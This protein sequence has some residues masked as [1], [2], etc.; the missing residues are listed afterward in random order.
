MGEG[1]QAFGQASP[2]LAM[3]ACL[4][5]DYILRQLEVN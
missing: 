1:T 3:A 2:P 4:T 5:A